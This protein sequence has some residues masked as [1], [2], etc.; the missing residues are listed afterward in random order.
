MTISA[1]LG[2]PRI[3]RA[4]ELKRALE[5]YWAGTI[6]A[7]EL[8]EVGRNIRLVNWDLQKGRGIDVIPSNDFSFYDQ[9]LDTIEMLGAVPTRYQG[10]VGVSPFDRYF[11]MARGTESLSAMEMTKWFDTNYHFIVPELSPDLTFEWDGKRVLES[12]QEARSHGITTR[13]VIVG[14]ITFLRLAKVKQGA[15]SA[16]AYLDDILPVYVNI[17]AALRDAGAEW[18]QIDEPA[19][20]LELEQEWL[21]AIGRAYR[22]LSAAAPRIMLATYFGKA[23]DK[24]ANLLSLPIGGVHLDLVRAPEQLENILDA[25]PKG[26]TLSL[27]LVDGRNIWRND[28][29]QSLTAAEKVVER[30]GPQNTQ[31][32]P[33]CSLLHVP[34]DLAEETD[35]DP[36][37]ASWLAFATQKLDEVV[38]LAGAADEGRD[39]YAPAFHDSDDAKAS[40]RA[41]PRVNK[42]GDADR[43]VNTARS[44]RSQRIEA[45]RDLSLPQ[46]PTT[47][48]GSFPQTEAVRQARA[49][50]KKGVLSAAQYDEFLK[51]ETKKA[52]SFQEEVGLDVLVHGEFERNDMVEYF[53][54]RLAG[55]LFTK[56]AWVQSYGSRCVK[57]PIIFGD[58][59]R[60]AP[61]TV[62]WTTYAQSLTQRPVKGMLTGPVTILQWSF[63]RDDQPRALTCQQIALAVYDEVVDLQAAG[64]RIIQIDEPALREGLPLR[65]SDWQE[66]LEWAVKCFKLASSAAGDSTQIHTHMCYAEFEDILPAIA[67]LDADVISI[68][69]SRSGM[70]LLDVFKRSGYA[71]DIGLGVY[72]IHA[73]RRPEVA[74]LKGKIESAAGVLKPEQIWVNPDC[75]LKTRRWE[76]VKPALANMVG[77]AKILRNESIR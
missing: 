39:A 68:E 72:D 47:T 53:G 76:E 59:S 4:R 69:A 26:K 73:P 19:L 43:N 46:F 33:S 56:K 30:I 5:A 49:T 51:E 65:A 13:P 64:I 48:I 63:V 31:V 36:E 2:F 22:V 41:S 21:E 17:L 25:W 67:E 77:A 75:G 1:N 40:R 37:I 38:V 16:L 62:K 28:L 45:Q 42:G 44:L 58:V 27:G 35:I 24:L 3:G 9:M 10:V 20:C 34:V 66:Y 29:S 71:N 52:I 60:P 14:P 8:E 11:A 57:P 18:V 55:F 61:M 70:D 50:F 54:E 6:S 32:A 15:K 12:F 74:E 23:D 7:N